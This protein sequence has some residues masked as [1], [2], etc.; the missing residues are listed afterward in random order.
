MSKFLR[1]QLIILLGLSSIS[2][3]G[4]V[5]TGRFPKNFAH[6]KENLSKKEVA[7]IKAGHS[8]FSKPWVQAPSSTLLRNGLGPNFNAVSCMSCHSGFGRGAPAGV[9]HPMDP[10]LLF[11]VVGPLGPYGPQIQPQAILGVTPEAQVTT[12]WEELP[13]GLSKPHYQLAQ[14]QFGELNKDQYLSPRIGPHLA[15]LGYLDQISDEEILKNQSNGGKANIVA[16]RVARFGWKADKINLRHQVA[17]AFQGDLGITNP[18]F[19]EQ[20]CSS[21]QLD[22]L[23]APTG[24]E[25]EDGH[26]YEL[27]EKHLDYVVEL[28]AGIEKPARQW[29]GADKGSILR[30][31]E[32]FETINCQSCHRTSYTSADGSEFSPYTDLLLHDMGEGLADQGNNL[33][34][35]LWR[36]APLWGL[37]SQ[38]L[39]NGHLQLLHDGR[40]KGITEAILWHGGEAQKVK[41]DFIELSSKKKTDLINFILSL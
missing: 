2:S 6:L 33:Q 14:E 23:A 9:I 11:K 21:D 5:L 18:L 26:N 10:S 7:R 29:K 20:P 16:G 3:S 35:K 25:Y 28:M 8:L 38:K 12:T 19:S 39:V 34:A 37:G 4:T 17:A 32:V 24:V 41:Q 40:A 27:S 1:I 30:G 13:N 31:Q 22:C 36:T 15:G